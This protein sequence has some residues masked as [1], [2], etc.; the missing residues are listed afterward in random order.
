MLSRRF[1]TQCSIHVHLDTCNHFLNFPAV[2]YDA[3][4]RQ[5][6]SK[7]HD[8]DEISQAYDS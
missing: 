8:V 4:I 7:N 1:P 3:Y 5:I 6:H 2:F